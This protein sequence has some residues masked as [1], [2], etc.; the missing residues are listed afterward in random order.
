MNE[1][2]AGFKRSKTRTDEFQRSSRPRVS[3]SWLGAKIL[4]HGA[5]TAMCVTPIGPI[6]NLYNQ[7]CAEE[8]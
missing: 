7:Q 2:L 4:S 1:S 5:G 6:S 3:G 8:H